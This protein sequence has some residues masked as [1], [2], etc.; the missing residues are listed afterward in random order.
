MP[1]CVQHIWHA[2]WL[3]SSHSLL[4]K[5][6]QLFWIC[7]P[8]KGCW[9]FVFFLD[10]LCINLFW[11][12]KT[13]IFCLLIRKSHS[14]SLHYT[15]QYFPSLPSSKIPVYPCRICAACCVPQS[16]VAVCQ[17][18]IYTFHSIHVCNVV[19]LS[20]VQAQVIERWVLRNALVGSL[21]SKLSVFCHN[22]SSL[23]ALLAACHIKCREC[24][25]YRQTVT[26][27]APM[28]VLLPVLQHTS[29]SCQLFIQH[30]SSLFVLSHI[31]MPRT[32]VNLVISNTWQ[33]LT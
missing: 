13:M 25:F 4:C 32:V 30:P 7:S 2:F 24:V 28:P 26:T 9:G 14:K 17:S 10:Y 29:S 5:R 19:E 23:L 27:S 33:I 31:I 6:E 11:W 12:L 8:E 16:L 3:V 21:I 18:I 22:S 20:S 15:V 1:K